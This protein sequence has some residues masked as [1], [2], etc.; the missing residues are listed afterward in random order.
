[1]CALKKQQKS[2]YWVRFSVSAD[3][4][5][6]ISYDTLLLVKQ[7]NKISTRATIW[8]IKTYKNIQY[9]TTTINSDCDYK[10]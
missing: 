9:R 5:R 6:Q 3:I 4:Q 2:N 10:R 8:G 1:M 7:T